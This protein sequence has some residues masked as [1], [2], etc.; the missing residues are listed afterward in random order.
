MSL[1]LL[2][3]L[4]AYFAADNT[5]GRKDGGAREGCRQLSQQPREA[6]PHLQD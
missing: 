3:L 6:Q 2:D 5:A 1:E 4:A